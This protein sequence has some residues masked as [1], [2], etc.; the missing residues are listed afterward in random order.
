MKGPQ[1]IFTRTLSPEQFGPLHALSAVDDG[2]HTKSCFLKTQ[3]IA[4]AEPFLPRG[5]LFD[6]ACA[7]GGQQGQCP[8]S[9]AMLVWGGFP[10]RLQG[11]P[12]GNQ[13]SK[14]SSIALVRVLVWFQGQDKYLKG[15]LQL[16]PRLTRSKASGSAY[17]LARP[18]CAPAR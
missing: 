16:R 2:C 5:S 6:I 4:E 13:L 14:S 7:F 12:R 1:Y 15:Q 10:P 3:H 18:A 8:H 9:A 17:C 11:L